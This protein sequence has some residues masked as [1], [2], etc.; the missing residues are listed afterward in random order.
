NLADLSRE[1]LRNT[2]VTQRQSLV[3]KYLQ[4]LLGQLA[5]VPV[6][7]LQKDEPVIAYLLDS[8]NTA[9]FK[10]RVEDALEVHLSFSGLLGGNSIAVIAREVLQQLDSDSTTW[11]VSGVETGPRPLS[12]GQKALWFLYKLAPESGA[13]NLAAAARLGGLLDAHRLRAAFR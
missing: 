2:P 10:Q 12:H 6:S 3:E 11:F 9:E 4:E 7:R 8:L 13:Y 1:T 5:R